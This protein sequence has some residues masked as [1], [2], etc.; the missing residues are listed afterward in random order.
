MFSES[1]FLA[2]IPVLDTRYKYPRIQNNNL[3][4]LF[5]DHLDY[6]LAYYFADSEITKCNIDK[7]FTNLLKKP[8][9]KKLSYYNID[10]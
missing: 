5:N 6:V 7:F 2:G 1:E 9:I 4:F 8:I 10:E 3:F